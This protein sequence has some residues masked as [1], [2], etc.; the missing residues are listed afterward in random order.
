MKK[1]L[2]LSDYHQVI[3]GKSELMAA[4]AGLFALDYEV[5]GE[6]LYRRGL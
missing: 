1:E 5:H 2:I 3:P 4:L 6:L